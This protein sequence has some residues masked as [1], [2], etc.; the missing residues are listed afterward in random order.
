MG[1]FF[2][3]EITLTEIEDVLKGFKKDKFLGMNGW[4]VEFFLSFFELVGTDLLR[5]V[6]QSQLEGKVLGSL[7][8]TFISLIPKC[9]KPLTFADFMPI[10][11][12]NLV[13]KT[14][15]NIASIRQKPFLD[16]AI[17]AH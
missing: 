3:A 10:S 13:Y 14:I 15:S 6:I 7:N 4:P 5:V 16:K 2:L 17:Y 1:F 12:C 8:D 11:L 9:D